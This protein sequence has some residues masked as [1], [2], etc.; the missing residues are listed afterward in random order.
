MDRQ[1]AEQEADRLVALRAADPDGE[2]T[3]ERMARGFDVAEARAGWDRLDEIVDADTA[4]GE[5]EWQAWDA[6]HSQH[7]P[8]E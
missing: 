3:S 6:E 4:R 8:P 5:A 2:I 7:T 1:E